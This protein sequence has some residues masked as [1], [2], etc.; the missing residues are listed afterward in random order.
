MATVINPV[1]LTRLSGT[2]L[3]TKQYHFVKI[4]G[5]D[6]N[7]VDIC[8]AIGEY[9]LGTVDCVI[10]HGASYDASNPDNINVAVDGIH[11]VVLGANLTAGTPITTDASGQA[12]GAVATNYALGILM[13]SGSTGEVRQYKKE[14]FL[15]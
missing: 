15:V 1:T 12:I 3:R 13:E 6:S 8:D 5:T 2:D 11:K 9:S 14:L 4:N 7:K 10:Q